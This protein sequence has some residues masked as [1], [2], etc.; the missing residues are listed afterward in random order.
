[1]MPDIECRP[2][3]NRAELRAS[4]ALR[5]KVFVEEQQLFSRTDRD[6]HDAHAI[7]IIA[8]CSGSIVGTVR[9]HRQKA[10]V[11]LGSRLAVLKQFRGRAGKLL[12]Q[13]AVEIV[14]KNGARQFRA[15]IQLRNVPLFRRLGWSPDGPVFSYHGQQHQTMEAFSSKQAD[16][17]QQ[18]AYNRKSPLAAEC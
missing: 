15:H 18:S 11:W 10:G 16:S 13:K 6:R 4:F 14:R 9:V 12:I 2:V 5:K 1:M 7:H 8:L 17:D 3:Q